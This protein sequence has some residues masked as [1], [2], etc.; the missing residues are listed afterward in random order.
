M[1][2]DEVNFKPSMVCPACGERH[3]VKYQY[4][5]ADILCC[6]K[7]EENQII[8]MPSEVSEEIK[9]LFE[10]QLKVC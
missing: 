3:E 8:L 10:N 1:T 5:G 6:P 2:K 4:R 7:M 9:D